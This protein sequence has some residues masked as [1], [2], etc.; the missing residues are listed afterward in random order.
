MNIQTQDKIFSSLN[1][2]KDQALQEI[3]LLSACQKLSEFQT[4]V[5][6]FEKKYKKSFKDFD[7]AFKKMGPTFEAENDWLSWKFATEGQLF[8]Q[9]L[10]KKN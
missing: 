3:A 5:A 9:E 7:K 10:T 1:L 2:S 4:E 8:W 6:Y